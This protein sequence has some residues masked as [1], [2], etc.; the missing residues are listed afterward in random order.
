[1]DG[2]RHGKDGMRVVINSDF[3]GPSL[4]RLAFELLLTRKGIE[5]DI[6]GGDTPSDGSIFIHESF[7]HKGHAGNNSFYLSDIDYMMNRADPD[8][9]YVIE[10]LGD[11]ANGPCASLKVI[12]IPDDIQWQINEYDGREWI[13]EEHRTWR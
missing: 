3:G 2:K 11:E 1:L 13:A 12:E 9:I 4:S 10:T 7:Y 5:Y 8:L 6:V